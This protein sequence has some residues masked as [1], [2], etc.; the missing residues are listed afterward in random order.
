MTRLATLVCF[1]I[2]AVGVLIPFSQGTA[3]VSPVDGWRYRQLVTVD[4]TSVS[5][6]LSTFPV[7]VNLNSSNFNFSRAKADGTDLRFQT[8]AGATLSFERDFHSTATS[9]AAYWVSVPTI[10][11]SSTTSFWMYYGNAAATDT[12]TPTTVWASYTGVYHFNGVAGTTAQAASTLS[13]GKC[14]WQG[15]IG[16]LPDGTMFQVFLQENALESWWVPGDDPLIKFTTS[17]DQGATW[18]APST[19]AIVPVSDNT[20]TYWPKAMATPGGKIILWVSGVNYRWRST[21]TDKGVT[22][23]EAALSPGGS[24]QQLLAIGGGLLADIWTE[25]D[26]SPGHPAICKISTTSDE[27]VTWSVPR[28]IYSDS[29]HYLNEPNSVY[30]GSNRILVNFRNESGDFNYYQAVSTDN[31]QTLTM[32]GGLNL[33]PTGLYE[34]A[35]GV[36]HPSSVW[37][38]TFTDG[39]GNLVVENVYNNRN[40]GV[41]QVIYAYASDLISSGVTA[42]KSS[43]NRTIANLSPY[44]E[45]T[46][47]PQAVRLAG[48]GNPLY[49]YTYDQSGSAV[50]D[51]H[52][53]VLPK[54]TAKN[55][56]TGFYDGV[57]YGGSSSATG[58]VATGV[59]IGDVQG[60]TTLAGD[61]G[62]QTVEFMFKRS[63]SSDTNYRGVTGRTIISWGGIRLRTS[64]VGPRVTQYNNSMSAKDYTPTACGNNDSWNYVGS[65]LSFADIHTLNILMQTNSAAQSGQLLDGDNSGFRSGDPAIRGLADHNA[66]GLDTANG[67]YDEFRYSNSARSAGWLAASSLSTRDQYLSFGNAITLQQQ[68]QTA[69]G[70]ILMLGLA[71]AGVAAALVIASHR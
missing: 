39:D 61:S 21:S 46:G 22:W 24:G 66:G 55:S 59:S 28:T 6:T 2:V 27:G 50:I 26:A 48:S 35:P 36:N 68:S 5:E 8:L 7:L 34:S 56:A 54:P 42:W 67:I 17:T 53:Y 38:S 32:Q 51:L 69:S 45:T 60:V 33:D 40:T 19:V 13:N 70:T 64:D 12:Q 43:T 23:S 29:T 3:P 25:G 1:V 71:V 18:G 9:T 37:M 63:E 20:Y 10:P 41:L 16:Q 65:S 62:N 31:G 49:V 57:L 44:P 58:L 30:L 47:W 11:A 14:N 52:F 4:N 15:S